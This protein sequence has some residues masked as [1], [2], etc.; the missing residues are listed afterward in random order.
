MRQCTSHY[1]TSGDQG[2]VQTEPFALTSRSLTFLFLTGPL[3]S[4]VKDHVARQV[5]RTILLPVR[6]FSVRAISCRLPPLCA[7]TARPQVHPRSGVAGTPSRSIT[8]ELPHARVQAPVPERSLG[9]FAPGV[10]QPTCAC[11][12]C[13]HQRGCCCDHRLSRFHNLSP[14]PIQPNPIGR[15]SSVGEINDTA[16]TNGQPVRRLRSYSPSR[17]LECT[18]VAGRTC[19]CERHRRSSTK[20]L[21]SVANTGEVGTPAASRRLAVQ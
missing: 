3:R 5:L 10:A 12:D 17:L 8:K 19:R 6:M 20:P 16:N 7:R 13:P 2:L 18:H 1:S 9:G 11:R 21:G 4:R 14:E 15:N